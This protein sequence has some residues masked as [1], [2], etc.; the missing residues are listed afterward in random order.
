[1]KILTIQE[2]HALSSREGHVA[3]PEVR[4]EAQAGLDLWEQRRQGA[5]LGELRRAR[6]L[7]AGEPLGVVAWRTLEDHHNQLEKGVGDELRHLLHGG[8]AGRRWVLEKAKPKPEPEPEDEGEDD[9]RQLRRRLSLL[10]G[11]HGDEGVPVETFRHHV[12]KHGHKA[13]A[14]ALH[15]LG[16]E[17]REGRI[18]RTGAQSPALVPKKPKPEVKKAF[19]AWRP[20]RFRGL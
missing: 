6:V 18:H 3:P 9:R 19:V 5:T 1:M 11:A 7:A 14:R 4:A 15:D 10:L 20:V 13:V 17:H 8:E 2:A 12:D 16:C